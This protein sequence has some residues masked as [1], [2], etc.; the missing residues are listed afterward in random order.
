M[1]DTNALILKR[2]FE[3]FVILGMTAI[4]RGISYYL[5]IVIEINKKLGGKRGWGKIYLTQK[6]RQMLGINF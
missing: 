2:I 1:Y 4:A 6:L 3:I 5:S